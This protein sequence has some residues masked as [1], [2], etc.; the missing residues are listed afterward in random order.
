MAA[1]EDVPATA[2]Y[3]KTV[4]GMIKERRAVIE[5]TNDLEEIEATIGCGQVEQLI[6]QAKDE[7]SLIPMLIETDAFSAY[8]GS[9]AEDVL[10]DLKRRGIALQR[11]DIP[12]RPSLDFP[13]ETEIELELPAPPEAEADK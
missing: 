10:T 12:M 2:E 8:D 13:T 6:Q 9:P 7:L 4:E 3:R 5:K 11:D 1:L